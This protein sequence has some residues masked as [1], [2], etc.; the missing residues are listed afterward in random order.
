M[1]SLEYFLVCESVSTDQETN[2]VSLFNILEDLQLG[3]QSNSAAVVAQFVAVSCFNR[4]TGDESQDFQ[5]ML[6]IHAPNGEM[7]EFPLNFRMERPRQRLTMRFFGLP[8]LEPGSLRFELLLNGQHV[9]WHTVNIF[10]S[11]TSSPAASNGSPA[12]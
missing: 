6:R 1:P 12:G 7:T 4:E 9:A 5:A 10:G 8:P 2:R 11:E 3:G